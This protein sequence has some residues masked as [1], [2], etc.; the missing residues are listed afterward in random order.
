MPCALQ[1]LVAAGA[2]LARLS[3]E[4]LRRVV[5]L[6]GRAGKVRGLHVE[7]SATAAATAAAVQMQH[8]QAG[9]RSSC[10][11]PAMPL[12]LRQLASVD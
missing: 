8:L 12:R 3:P 9:S 2:S 5:R 6:L 10:R 1:V 4:E 11:T 7:Q